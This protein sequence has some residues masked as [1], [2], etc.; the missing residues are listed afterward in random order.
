MSDL[1]EKHQELINLVFKY[2]TEKKPEE[3]FKIFVKDFIYEDVAS[4]II[5]RNP[6]E[7]RA[8]MNSTYT[9]APDIKFVLKNCFVNGNNGCSEWIM[10]GTQTG[11]LQGGLPT[12]NKKFEVKGAS[13]YT[14]D[15]DKVKTCSDYCDMMTFMKQI[16]VIKQ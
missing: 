1:E 11:P 8:F 13:T 7:L 4:G 14:F 9:M 16:G 6:D 15:G 2:W 5:S 10:V 12:T 3:L